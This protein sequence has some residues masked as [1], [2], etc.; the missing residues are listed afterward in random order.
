MVRNVS[1]GIVYENV[2]YFMENP[3]AACRFCWTICWGA[4]VNHVKTL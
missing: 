1:C 3:T 2:Y 4:V